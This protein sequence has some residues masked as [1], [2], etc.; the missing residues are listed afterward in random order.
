MNADKIICPNCKTEIPI[1][2]A[3]QVQIEGRIRKEYDRKWEARESAL[4]ERED[5]ASDREKDLVIERKSFEVLV[6]NRV[7]ENLE[8]EREK[9]TT[10]I[11]S[12][13]QTKVDLELAQL[14]STKDAQNKTI[15]EYKAKILDAQKKQMEA[16]QEKE[17][18]EIEYQEKLNEEKGKIEQKVSG[19]IDEKYRLQMADKDKKLSDMALQLDETTRKLQQGSQQFQGEVLELELE[20]ILKSNFPHDSIIPIPKGVKGADVLQKVLSPTGESCGTIIWESKRTK[21]W[22]D[23]WIKKLKDDQLEQ[24]ADLAIIYS[25][26]LP[27]DIK[28]FTVIEDVWITCHTSLLSIATALRYSLIEIAR[29]KTTAIGKNQK[30]E[31]LFAYLTGK[32]FAQ[33]VGVILQ[34]YIGMKNQLDQEKRAINRIWSK[35]EKQIERVQTNLASMYGGLEEIVGASLPQLEA[36]ELTALPDSSSIESDSTSVDGDS[37][38]E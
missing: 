34:T 9:L 23:T 20:Q 22:S 17:N 27:K 1:T 37:L 6:S 25:S 12:E 32:E 4:K 15:V 26:I 10:E 16:N 31:L 2:E 21:T 13:E 7:K 19:R 35:R 3:L 36:L 24:K 28:D 8:K 30:M 18:L 33:R 11:R 5:L 29:I 38:A 14:K